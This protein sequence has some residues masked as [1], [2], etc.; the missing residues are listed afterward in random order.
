[1]D[2]LQSRLY[3]I[4]EE[5]ELAFFKTEYPG[6]YELGSPAAIQTLYRLSQYFGWAYRTYRYGPYTHD[7]RVI[8]LTREIGKAWAS[9]EFPG[10]AFR[11]SVDERASL[12]QAVVRHVGE[13][14]TALPVFEPISLYEFEAEVGDEQHKHAR[15]YRTKA[16]CSTLA[17]IDRADTAEALEGHERLAVLQ[18]LLVDLLAYIESREGFSVSI[19]E[20]RKA[21]TRGSYVRASPQQPTTTR[22]LHQ[23]PGRIRLGIS[24]LKTDEAYAKGLQSLLQSLQSVTSVR[25]N[26]AASSVTIFF[27]P[28]IAQAEFAGTLIKTIEERFSAAYPTSN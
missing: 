5:D 19:G 7:S 22:I 6:Q 9:R 27:S 2:H 10:D 13:V 3:R 24:R 21:R 1:M 17:A 8:D 28:D 18:N 15:L 20:R 25:I 23:S 11:F 26:A 4:L 14:S 16:V 12:G